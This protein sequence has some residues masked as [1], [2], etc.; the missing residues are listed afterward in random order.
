MCLCVRTYCEVIT[1]CE[2]TKTE[3]R[4]CIVMMPSASF[5]LVSYHVLGKLTLAV[6]IR[7]QNAACLRLK[8][9]RRHIPIIMQNRKKRCFIWKMVYQVIFLCIVCLSQRKEI[10]NYGYACITMGMKEKKK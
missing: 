2:Q 7:P 6:S 8:K 9:N 10:H 5:Y 3:I 4:L 1:F